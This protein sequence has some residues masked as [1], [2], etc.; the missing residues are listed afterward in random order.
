M[1]ANRASKHQVSK[2]QILDNDTK[3]RQNNTTIKNENI[4]EDLEQH[5]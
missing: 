3:N 1:P 2:N 5:L 4:W